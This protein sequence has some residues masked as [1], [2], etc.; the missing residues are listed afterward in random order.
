MRDFHCPKCFSRGSLKI[1]ADQENYEILIDCPRCKIKMV[2]DSISKNDIKWISVKE[3]LPD[4]NK[5]CL[6]YD[7]E[8]MYVTIPDTQYNMEFWEYSQCC[9]CHTNS[10]VT[11]WRPLPDPPK[12]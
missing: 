4:S 1:E 11:H 7:G 3:R 9:G 5:P 6:C 8:K 12:E 2:E 10:E